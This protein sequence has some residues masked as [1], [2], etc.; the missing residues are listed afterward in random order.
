[1]DTLLPVARLVMTTLP[2][3]TPTRIEPGCASMNQSVDLTSAFPVGQ[4]T[5][6]NEN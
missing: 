3:S 6:K 2:A 5:S 4:S 1:M